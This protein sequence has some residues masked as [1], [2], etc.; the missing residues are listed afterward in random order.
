MTLAN[1]RSYRA[2]LI[3]WVITL[4]TLVGLNALAPNHGRIRK[5]DSTEITGL[6]QLTDDALSPARVSNLPLFLSPQL[7]ESDWAMSL[8]SQLLCIE[9]LRRQTPL[10]ARDGAIRGRA[11][12]AGPCA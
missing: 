10:Q 7:T 11:P 5:N 4:V 6:S 8:A 1:H 3:P 9:T 12:P 2:V